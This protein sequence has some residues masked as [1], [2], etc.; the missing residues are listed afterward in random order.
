KD[1]KLDDSL[2]DLELY[3][4][5]I[6]PSLLNVLQ[7]KG[8]E[9]IVPGAARNPRGG[10][11]L[12]SSS[13]CPWSTPASRQERAVKGCYCGIARG[14]GE[15]QVCFLQSFSSASAAVKINT[16]PGFDCLF[17]CCPV[18]NYLKSFNSLIC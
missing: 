6:Q 12:L 10:S 17:Q 9:H 18:E 8:V 4:E 1:L 7:C 16:A 13:L 11:S 15:G 3:P 5:L 2:Q 14:W